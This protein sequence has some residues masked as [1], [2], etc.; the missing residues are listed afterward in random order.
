MLDPTGP[1]QAGQSAM[2]ELTIRNMCYRTYK[3]CLELNAKGFSH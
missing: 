3:I 1:L 2:P